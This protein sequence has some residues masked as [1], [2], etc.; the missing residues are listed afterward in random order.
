[1]PLGENVVNEKLNKVCQA[2]IWVN[3]E[4]IACKLLLR[5]LQMP[6]EW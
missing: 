3:E 2:L 6:F 4:D 5:L 1:M